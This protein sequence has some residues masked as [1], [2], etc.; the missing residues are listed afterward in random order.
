MA[1]KMDKDIAETVTKSVTSTLK[2]IKETFKDKDE[3]IKKLL[4]DKIGKA[5]DVTLRIWKHDDKTKQWIIFVDLPSQPLEEVVRYGVESV[6][7][8]QGGGGHYKVEYIFPD[9]DSIVQYNIRLAGHSYNESKLDREKYGIATGLPGTGLPAVSMGDKSYYAP[10]LL[11]QVESANK[12]ALN[13]QSQSFDRMMQM[14]MMTLMGNSPNQQRQGGSE[15][16][17]ELATMKEELRALKEASTKAEQAREIERQREETRRLQDKMEQQAKE[18]DLKLQALSTDNSKNRTEM[19]IES[20]KAELSNRSRVDAPLME[21]FRMSREDAV[22]NQNTTLGLFKEIM[23][24]PDSTDQMARVQELVMNSSLASLNMMGQVMESGLLGGQS[25]GVAE[26]VRDAIGGL[27]G[28]LSAYF[29]KGGT[30]EDAEG[31]QSMPHALIPAYV[32]QAPLPELPEDAQTPTMGHVAE[33]AEPVT[34][35]GEET[36]G[37]APL[38]PTKAVDDI[39]ITLRDLLKDI[40][41]NLRL[42]ESMF[43]QYQA[44]GALMKAIAELEKGT[45]IS[46][47]TTRIFA[48][49][50]HGSRE[51]K[52][53]L[54]HPV[55]VTG[56]LL[57]RYGGPRTQARAGDLV[58]DILKFLVFLDASGD[59]NEWATTG[60]RPVKSRTQPKSKSGAIPDLPKDKVDEADEVDGEVDEIVDDTL[61]NPE[62]ETDQVTS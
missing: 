5:M 60:Y 58:K 34:R 54:D 9:G 42:N 30:P 61:Q 31:E 36:I 47:I 55:E 35:E 14:F 37:E 11:K 57:A 23:S 24:K 1:S 44:Q 3:G 26:I 22:S 19:A 52:F 4:K 39:E 40:P 16:N 62:E 20:L 41:K 48:H 12:T 33:D 2:D 28:V 49:H 32:D 53:W 50:V 25:G 15:T 27:T 43:A 59:P 10:D 38:D 13:T 46:E 6:C 56:Q 29:G 18:F 51:A 17:P 8:D 7:K 21:M 45:P